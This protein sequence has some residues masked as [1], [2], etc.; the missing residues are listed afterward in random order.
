MNVTL[1]LSLQNKLLTV[2]ELTLE[3]Q[4]NRTSVYNAFLDTGSGGTLFDTDMVAAIGIS[5]DTGMDIR[6]IQGIGEPET[7]FEHEINIEVATLRLDGFI[8][9]I[10]N[11]QQYGFTAL[12]GLDFLLAT[13]AII[14]LDAMTLT[15]R[16]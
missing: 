10:G 16:T 4:G 11:M 2:P 1:P 15:L 14:D 12:I 8:A 6:T 3:F 9:E 13:H 5:Y 7:V